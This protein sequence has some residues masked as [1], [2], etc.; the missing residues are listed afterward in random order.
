MTRFEPGDPVFAFTG[1][2]GGCYVDYKCVPEDGNVAPRP[3]RLGYEEA[4]ALSFG[5]TTALSFLRRAW[6]RGGE[7]VL[8]VG[9][10]GGVGTAAV[11]LAK[12]FGAEV[13]G[14][15]STGNL[16]L[17]KS[18]G[19]DRV[20]DYTREDFT[21]GG[22]YDVIMDTTGTAPYWRCR[23][24]LKR[25]GRLLLVLA[26][27]PAMLTGACVSKMGRATIIAGPATDVTRD[28]LC[29]LAELAEAGAFRPVID[30]RYPLERIVEAH[31]YVDTG[32]KR[33]NVVITMANGDEGSDC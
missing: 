27:L 8:I 26:D 4:A 23:R 12:R 25:G 13:T 16:E 2:E 3:A 32:R 20:I 24:S 1:A 11:Q 5:G 29:L 28:D 6:L 22:G 31:R 14:V 30:R 18:L 17:V 7:K 19:A 33:G 10:S 21:H 15:C 9:A